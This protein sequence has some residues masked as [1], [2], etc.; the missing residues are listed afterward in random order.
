MYHKHFNELL[1]ID[2]ILEMNNY[3]IGLI[4]PDSGW[5]TW[6]LESTLGRF[7]VFHTHSILHDA[8]GRFFYNHS[9]DRGY[10]YSI[11]EHKTNNFMKSNPLCGQISG[12]L[13]C[14]HR[15]LII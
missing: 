8:F 14:V 4:G 3:D 2:E 5:L 15:K 11:P 10:L 13:Y 12:I 6:L 9:L 1:T 7:Q